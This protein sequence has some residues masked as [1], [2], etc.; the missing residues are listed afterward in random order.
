MRIKYLKTQVNRF[1][2]FIFLPIITL[3]LS[4]CFGSH[5]S[6]QY[7]SSGT[8]AL[9]QNFPSPHISI[10]SPTDQ[11]DVF[12]TIEVK[13]N[14]ISNDFQAFGSV[15]LK[16][17]EVDAGSLKTPPFQFVINTKYLDSGI[18]QL[19]LSVNSLSGEV[20]ETHDLSIRVRNYSNREITQTQSES[21]PFLSL[22]INEAGT[23]LF[24]ED[25]GFENQ[26]RISQEGNSILINL[27]GNI[28]TFAGPFSQIIVKAGKG[29]S[30][31]N[32]DSSVFA[33][34]TIYGGIGSDNLSSF[35]E[36]QN[37]IITLNSNSQTTLSGDPTRTHLWMN[38]N[39][40][41][42]KILNNL[43]KTNQIHSIYSFYQPWTQDPSQPDYISLDFGVENLKDPVDIGETHSFSSLSDPP[44]A[45]L[46]GE[47]PQMTDV[48][49]GL[50]GDCYFMAVIAS[51]AYQYE[52]GMIQ[53][54][55]GNT[56]TNP[57][58][59]RLYDLVVDLG[60]GTYAVQYQQNGVP[61]YVRVNGAFSTSYAHPGSSGDLWAL[62]ME[63]SY[64]YIH[65]GANSYG[66]LNGGWMGT[67]WSELGIESS[68]EWIGKLSANDLYEKV[69]N[70]LNE[71]RGITLG[72][73]GSITHGTPLIGG[74]AYSLIGTSKDILGNYSFILRNPWGFDGVNSDSNPQDGLI[75]VTY[76]QIIENAPWMVMTNH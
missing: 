45:S 14:L 38:G 18:H 55:L 47:G 5:D 25:Q 67:S 74:H 1:P 75:K 65:T 70:A 8:Q 56:P 13:A 6:I 3:L 43:E 54:A 28:K 64:A 23:V 76:L 26:L 21:K 31:I 11:S 69:L 41:N 63:K 49:Q 22:S 42:I 50:V 39:N 12:G 4:G 27:N 73:N 51:L 36:G 24:I 48:N 53:L 52:T 29:N 30:I 40:P 19:T 71:N 10:E 61:V 15:R 60:D 44:M 16:V 62:V 7:T 46:M 2:T 72:T 57:L 9:G 37:Q 58:F 59:N 66:S 35:A 33:N 32:I 34:T 68:T 20:I 17:D